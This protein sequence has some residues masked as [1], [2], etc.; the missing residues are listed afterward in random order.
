MIWHDIE[1]PN[2]PELDALGKRY[3][4]H[5]L[6]I[7]DC[8]HRNQSAKVEWMGGYMFIVLK[9]VEMEEDDRLSIGDLDLF[10]GADFFITVQETECK[11]VRE[12]IPRV[13]E[14]SEGR[15]TD[16][17]MYQIM[18]GIV[19]SYVPILDGLNERIDEL[20]DRVLEA[21]SP[22]TLERVF[23][24]KRAL[25][26]LRRVLTNTRDVAAH[27]LRTD[28]PLVAKDLAPFLRD[29]YDHIARSLDMVE[30][31]RDLLSGA[32]DIYLSSISNRT[33]QVMKV[34]TI[35]STIALP[36]IV[37]SG[38]YG[39]NVPGLPFLKHPHGG[40]IISGMIAATC[41][42]LLVIVRR[43]RWF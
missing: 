13:R 37:I 39:M 12:L 30:L 38:V 24:L 32:M 18:D 7:E 27:L 25:I 35:L 2:S 20:E 8:R 11:C 6:H 23:D 21:P 16:E 33:N 15:R 5:P 17:L 28:S 42:V 1:D 9:L 34:L 26:E 40:L 29:V 19:D 41:L 31:Q 36:A 3:G 4:L 43:L 22:Q 14:R 10:V